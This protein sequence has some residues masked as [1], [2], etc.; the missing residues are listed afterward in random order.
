M[1]KVVIG[2]SVVIIAAILWLAMPFTP[3][4]VEAKPPEPVYAIP[5]HIRY[6]FTLTNTSNKLLEKAEFWTYAP[7]KRTPSQLTVSIEA[8]HPYALVE[9]SSGN[10]VLYFV[11]D[12]IPPFSR[13]TI[14]IKAKLMLANTPNPEKVPN[15]GNYLKAETYMEIQDAGIAELAGKLNSEDTHQ[16]TENIFNWVAGHI[17]YAGFSE[18]ERGARYALKNKKGDCTEF[19]YLFAALCRACQIPARCIGGYVSD[20]NTILKANEYH[21]WAE[22][23][24]NGTWHV[25]DP[26]EKVFMEHQDHYIAMRILKDTEE[27]PMK[28]YHR[29]RY[30][31]KGL[32][33]RMN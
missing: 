10:Q 19:M 9:D 12:H 8:S 16:T 28:N 31:G 18:N 3:P 29:F 7:V 5:R 11:F 20:K 23:Y 6:G 4:P 14:T 24:A 30:E 21:N 13:K 2:F 32:K 17:T 27:N 33:V 25:A 26:S 15:I 1:K 22:F